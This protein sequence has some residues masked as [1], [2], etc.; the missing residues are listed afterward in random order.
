LVPRIRCRSKEEEEHGWPPPGDVSGEE[1]IPAKNAKKKLPPPGNVSGE[2]KRETE[3]RS[4]L[5]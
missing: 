1:K 3:S 4:D 5:K 2:E